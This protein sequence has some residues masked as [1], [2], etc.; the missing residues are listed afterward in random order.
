ML[1]DA[2]EDLDAGYYNVPCEVLDTAHI[3]PQDIQS[4]AYRAWVKSRIKLAREYFNAGREYIDRVENTRCRLA[5]FAY[6][7]RFE[8][9]LNTIEHEAYA[10]RPEYR[11]R[12]SLRTKY[13]MALLTLS[14]IFNSRRRRSIYQPAHTRL[15]R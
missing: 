1:R 5:G 6:V 4:M 8:W 9:L 15:W 12:K 2:Y 13:R 14:S 3:H 7:A 10:L 11:E